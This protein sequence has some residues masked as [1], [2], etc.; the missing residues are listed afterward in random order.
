[1]LCLLYWVVESQGINLESRHGVVGSV[2]LNSG[3]GK[4]VVARHGRSIMSSRKGVLSYLVL[5]DDGRNSG[6]WGR[7]IGAMECYRIGDKEVDMN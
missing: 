4:K 6:L 7:V 2:G 1:V 3:C 5:P